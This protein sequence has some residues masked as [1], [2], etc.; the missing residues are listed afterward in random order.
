MGSWASEAAKWA[1]D[2]EL[3]KYNDTPEKR[4]QPKASIARQKGKTGSL[5]GPFCVK[6]RYRYRMVRKVY[7]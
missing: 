3:A 5:A 4:A 6:L 7:L 2:L 1:P